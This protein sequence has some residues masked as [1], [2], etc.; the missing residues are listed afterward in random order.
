MELI[1]EIFGCVKIFKLKSRYDNRGSLTYL[2]DGIEGFE[3]KE[4]RIY[5][6]PSEGTFF[7]I[8]YREENEPMSKLI[9]VIR[10]R[11][12]DYVVDLR[13]GS[14]T[15]LSSEAFELS[16]EN[17]LAVFIPAGIGHAFLSL[18]DDTVQLFAIDRSAD[19]GYSKRIN[20]ADE[21]I[22]LE[23]PIPISRISDYD[24]SAKF[25][26]ELSGG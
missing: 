26:S 23:L 7:G 21:K 2:Y 5:D 3:I 17:G 13:K 10:G 11:G 6:M 24:T 18:E 16:K 4:N 1:R 22:G 25:L 15:Y 8:H 14:E 9:T 20:Y 19:A 12:M